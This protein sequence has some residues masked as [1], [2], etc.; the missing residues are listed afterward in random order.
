M[1]KVN[2]LII[3]ILSIF[4]I[5]LGL[6]AISNTEVTFAQ[7]DNVYYT[8]E[9]NEGDFIPNGATIISIKTYYGSSGYTY[10]LSLRLYTNVEDNNANV[11][12]QTISLTEN[13]PYV[14]QTYQEY[15][16]NSIS[17]KIYDG[18]EVIAADYNRIILSPA[19]KYAKVEEQ[20]Y[21]VKITCN[22]DTI[23]VNNWYKVGKINV[24]LT[25]NDQSIWEKEDG[26]YG[27][28]YSALSLEEKLTSS[29]K[30]KF[31]AKEN[32]ILTF[33]V[34]ESNYHDRNIININNGT[35]TSKILEKD[36]VSSGYIQQ[37]YSI[38]N[39]GEYEFTIENFHS[40]FSQNNGKYYYNSEMFY[41]KDIQ[42]LTPLNTGEQLDTSLVEDGDTIYYE[43]G[44]SNGTMFRNTIEYKE[45]QE[46][47]PGISNPETNS[48][49]LYIG[50]LIVMF[51]AT[52]ILIK[53]N[54]DKLH[55]N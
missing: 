32:D 13:S 9:L 41:I 17:Q 22:D 11:S 35:I 4:I 16:T 2:R 50:I 47:N 10:P 26:K 55:N 33:D 53:F 46:E 37:K 51:T 34:K 8:D 3:S 14:I 38:E 31:N 42:V 36:E 49:I 1:K 48:N 18:W 43:C 39:D 5:M 28:A 19:E 45:E 24:E 52:A 29:I 40:S 44:C 54:S 23:A 7:E 27:Y 15:F 6:I 12:N 21:N 30:F 25:T 20:D